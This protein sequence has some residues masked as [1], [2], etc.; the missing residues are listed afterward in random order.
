M[1]RIIPPAA[2]VLSMFLL[3]KGTK[4]PLPAAIEDMSVNH[5]CSDILMS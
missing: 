2:Q 1:T 3:V 5:R 4:N